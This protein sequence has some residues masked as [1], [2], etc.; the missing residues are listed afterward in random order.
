[1]GSV[2]PW[3]TLLSS[4]IGGSDSDD[5]SGSK[6]LG[7]FA[8][9]CIDTIYK[10]DELQM[11]CGD[12]KGNYYSTSIPKDQIDKCTNNGD[13]IANINGV[14]KCGDYE[15][16]KGKS[17]TVSDSKYPWCS[18]GAETSNGWGWENNQSCRADPKA[19][20]K[21]WKTN[22]GGSKHEDKNDGGEE[23]YGGHSCKQQK[24]GMAVSQIG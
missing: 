11:K 23:S 18:S 8:S 15:S 12:G 17:T 14:L 5:N 3:L 4:I 16:H 9:S 24:S 2:F 6:P 20:V 7:S 10:D 19:S 21:N 22:N 13:K 1:M